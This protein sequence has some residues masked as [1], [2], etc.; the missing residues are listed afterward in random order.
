[1]K[2]EIE[3]RDASEPRDIKLGDGK[4]HVY[5]GHFPYERSVCVG[6]C[7]GKGAGEIG[8][9]PYPDSADALTSDT[10]YKPDVRIV[11]KNTESLDVVLGQLLHARKLMVSENWPPSGVDT[12]KVEHVW[13]TRFE[14]DVMK[15]ALLN[16]DRKDIESV[17]DE[18]YAKG[19]IDGEK[20]A[21]RE[22]GR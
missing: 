17:K 7:E 3:M 1:M 10:E 15:A 20:A 21:K 13:M 9:H 19:Y 8:S 5:A 6:F 18:F 14:L 22:A 4:T 16:T 11:F 2:V 12:Q